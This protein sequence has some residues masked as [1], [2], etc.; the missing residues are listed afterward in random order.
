[1]IG[2]FEVLLN[3]GINLIN[4]IEGLISELISFE[5]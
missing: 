2:S 4:Q 5:T 1:M 3:F